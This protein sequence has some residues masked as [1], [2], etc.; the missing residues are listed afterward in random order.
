MESTT[1]ELLNQ[2]SSNITELNLSSKN[3]SGILDLS[4]FQDLI[5][6][7]CSNNKITNLENLSK[8]LK[9]L[10][11]FDNNITNLDNLPNSLTELY[12]SHDKLT[13]LEELKVKY[14][15]LLYKY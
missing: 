13:N 9:S 10:N 5:K 1:I 15:K 7:N 11:F 8:K 2:Y 4:K 14:P 3:I 6:L 12:C